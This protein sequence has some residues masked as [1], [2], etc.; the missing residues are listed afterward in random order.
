MANQK[1]LAIGVHKRVVATVAYRHHREL[2]DSV[3]FGA[4]ESSDGKFSLKSGLNGLYLCLDNNL[5]M[6]QC[7]ASIKN[8]EPERFEKVCLSNDCRVF[9]LCS[10]TNQK[11]ITVLTAD[12][13]NDGLLTVP[14]K[15]Y[16]QNKRHKNRHPA[17]RNLTAIRMTTK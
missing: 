9:G 3:L 12:G 8:Q 5:L 2:N 1:V 10:V 6:A 11:L 17:Q 7:N 15:Y 14:F 4:E 13:E 16:E